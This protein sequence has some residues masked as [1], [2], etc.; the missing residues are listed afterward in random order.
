MSVSQPPKAAN[1]RL[2][3]PY[4]LILLVL[5]AV[6]ALSGFP[7]NV[8]PAQI[9]AGVGWSWT[10]YFSCVHLV[11][12]LVL[13]R[14]LYGNIVALAAL[15]TL[16]VVYAGAAVSWAGFLLGLSVTGPAAAGSH[17]VQLC[18][19]MLTV[20]PLALALVS[21]V[22]FG[23]IEQGLLLSGEGVTPLQ[24]KILMAMRVFSHIAFFVLPGT[25]E[26]LREE[27]SMTHWR[28]E[29]KSGKTTRVSL[30]G[31]LPGQLVMLSVEITSAAL[32]YVPLWAHEIARL[33]DR[34]GGGSGPISDES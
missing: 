16:P 34:R 32:Q 20:V 17:Y 6:P 14:R 33:P 22:P 21:V 26:V 5:S 7:L 1:G 27:Q 3:W 24:K 15:I 30:L 19:T 25:L 12:G 28:R 11:S 2:P 9:V 23:R 10:F 31:R 29:W 18:L 13:G 4:N 8:W